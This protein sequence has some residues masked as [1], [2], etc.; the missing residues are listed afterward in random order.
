[1][2]KYIALVTVTYATLAAVA[3]LNGATK[4][5]AKEFGTRKEAET[6]ARTYG[7]GDDAATVIV[8][9][10]ENGGSRDAKD[11]VPLMQ[12][13]YYRGK[14]HSTYKRVAALA[15][16]NLSVFFNDNR[17]HGGKLIF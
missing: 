2:K 9:A 14:R 10:T 1:M 8:F 17:H 15:D 6:Y 12:S 16:L 7:S 13:G 5:F 11:Y 3:N 4:T